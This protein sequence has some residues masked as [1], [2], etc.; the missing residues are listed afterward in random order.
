VL[1]VLGEDYILAAR[2]KG[3]TERI[4]IWR[5]VFRNALIPVVTIVGLNLGRMM[6]GAIVTE[7]VFARPGVG[8]LLIESISARDYPQ[9]QA[10]V[11]FFAVVFIVVNGFV[12]ISYS[13]ID[14]RVEHE[15]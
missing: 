8:R 6:G 4:V 1:D 7:T 5:H 12:D 11:A 10:T 2:S 9:I 13:Y 14:P 3:L 15:V